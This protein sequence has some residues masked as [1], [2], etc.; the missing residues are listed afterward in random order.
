M[1]LNALL[2]A[3]ILAASA[4]T[5]AACGNANNPPASG[6]S[7]GAT[8]STGTNGSGQPAGTQPQGGATGG[9]TAV[10]VD[11]DLPTYVAAGAVSGSLKSVG[12]DTMNNLMAAWGS[13]FGEFYPAATIAVEGAGSSTAPPALI[14]SQAQF[15]PMSRAMRQSEI[16]AFRDQFGYEPTALKAAIDCLAVY[17][18]RDCP[19]ES[20]TIPQIK[21]VFGGGTPLT[22][23]DLGV[24]DPAWAEQ[25]IALYGRNEASGTYG[26]FKEVALGGADYRE[27]VR[28]QGGSSG[29]VQAVG[30]DPFSMGYSGI[31]YRT[32]NVRPLA[33]ARDE[34]GQAVPP[35][36]EHALD[37]SYPLARFLFVYV[38]YDRRAQLQPAIAE[39]VRLIFSRQGQEG[40]VKDGYF[41]VPADIAREQLTSV[42]LE[43]SF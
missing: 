41:P 25:P 34:D 9:E 36:S 38:N 29:V 11:P 16:D 28:V 23:G 37:G 40:V 5:L 17:V 43:A 7:R 27:T 15:G 22:W 33:I 32:A 2:P 3:I 8:P 10:T 31:G 18:H 12:S 42:G 19:L 26:F 39:F 14:Q 30:T 1:R 20:I 21:A 13:S 4:L 6:G 35:T 24:D